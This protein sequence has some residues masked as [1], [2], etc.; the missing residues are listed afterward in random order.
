MENR[1]NV[2]VENIEAYDFTRLSSRC[3]ELIELHTDY[4]DMQHEKFLFLLGYY[5]AMYQYFS[6]LYTYL[7]GRV[8]HH[9]K[10]KTG[11]VDNVR[12]KR[13]MLEQILKVTKMQY[14]SLSRKIT[15]LENMDKRNI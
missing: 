7:I 11:G 12:D 4:V 9:S 6:E 14:D 15:V 2:T 8:R 1:D 3:Y 13:D 10:Q 5:S